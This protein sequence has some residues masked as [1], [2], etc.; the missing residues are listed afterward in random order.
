MTFGYGMDQI[1]IMLCGYSGIG[2]LTFPEDKVLRNFVKWSLAQKSSK[3]DKY[4][5]STFLIYPKGYDINKYGLFLRYNESAKAKAHGGGNFLREALFEAK[6]KKFSKEVPAL[7]VI[8]KKDHKKS[9]GV[10]RNIPARMASRKGVD[11]YFIDRSQDKE[12]M[13]EMEKIQKLP[14]EAKKDPA[15]LR[16]SLSFFKEYAHGKK[17]LRMYRL[18]D[19]VVTLI[20]H[21]GKAWQ[22]VKEIKISK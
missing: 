3:H 20:E 9:Q 2:P 1:Y 6:D 4:L 19:E 5:K 13:N 16:M 12:L 18:R 21:D 11:F 15:K 10:M 17:G 8:F 22:E 7:K 14:E